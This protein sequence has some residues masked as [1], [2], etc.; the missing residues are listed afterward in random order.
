MISMRRIILIIIFCVPGYF[1]KAQVATINVAKVMKSMPMLLKSDTLI[2]VERQRYIPA[3]QQMIN[4]YNSKAQYYDSIASI[5]STTEVKLEVSELKKLQDSI[6][7]YQK[8]AEEKIADY[9][10]V[11]QQP[12]YEKIQKAIDNVAKRLKYKQVMDIGEVR[13]VYISPLSDITDLVIKE[14]KIN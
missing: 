9:K 4:T 12:Y 1:S 8:N 2:E 5:K 6:L 7:S 11:L 14:I 13:F 10:Q 3:L